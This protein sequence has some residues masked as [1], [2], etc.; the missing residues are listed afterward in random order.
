MAKRKV[1]LGELDVLLSGLIVE[2]P[3]GTRV[4]TVNGEP[5]LLYAPAYVELSCRRG[6][7]RGLVIGALSN[8]TQRSSGGGFTARRVTGV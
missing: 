6:G 8:R 4:G 3:A 1:T 5:S 7:F 2:V